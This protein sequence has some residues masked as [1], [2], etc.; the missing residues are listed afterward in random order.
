MVWK[1]WAGWR[2]ISMTLL[3]REVVVRFAKFRL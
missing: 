1:I 2:W 3:S